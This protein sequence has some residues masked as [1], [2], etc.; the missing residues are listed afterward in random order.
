MGCD[1]ESNLAVNN[2]GA[3][4]RLLRWVVY[5]YA[6]AL[7]EVIRWANWSDTVGGTSSDV[8][9]STIDRLILRGDKAPVQK[10]KLETRAEAIF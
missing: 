9:T 1:R 5:C 10:F 8:N 7:V 3:L 4:M 6:A 2:F